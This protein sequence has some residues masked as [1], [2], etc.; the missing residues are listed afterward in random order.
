MTTL[1][2]CK[3]WTALGV[4]PTRGSNKRESRNPHRS[5]HYC[6][7]T[8]CGGQYTPIKGLSLGLSLILHA[9]NSINALAM[10]GAGAGA[11]TDPLQDVSWEVAYQGKA[12]YT[13]YCET[14]I[15]IIYQEDSL[16]VEDAVPRRSCELTEDDK[17]KLERLNISPSS[18]FDDASIMAARY[19]LDKR[20]TSVRVER[21]KPGSPLHRQKV[22]QMI[23]A[24][25]KTS[26]KP[27]GK[28]G[29]NQFSNCMTDW[30]DAN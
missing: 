30:L 9:T 29:T 15:L 19:A 26:S 13:A 1:F 20:I 4:S 2:L 14:E 8:Q 10:A 3:Q 6:I 7:H 23:E 28:H 22:M 21:S 11:G 24:T 27:A 16:Q 5:G 12:C 17:N 18:E 25:M